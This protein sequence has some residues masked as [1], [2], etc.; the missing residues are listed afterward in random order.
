MDPAASPWGGPRHDA[1][2]ALTAQPAV[3]FA[4][5]DDEAL[6]AEVVAQ[7]TQLF[8]ALLAVF[9]P[10]YAEPPYTVAALWHLSTLLSR[11][12]TAASAEASRLHR[13]AGAEIRQLERQ[14][15]CPA[16]MSPRELHTRFHGIVTDDE[17]ATCPV[18]QVR[19]RY[20]LTL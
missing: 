3:V 15:T 4:L 8:G 5:L 18:Q 10:P 13:R 6:D 1:L 7:K 17:R 9:D 2:L 12:H 14:H 16:C 20:G 11:W 19:R